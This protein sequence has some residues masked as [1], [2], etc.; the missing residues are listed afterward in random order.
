M[1]E[2]NM[3]ACIHLQWCFPWSTCP[4][5]HLWFI[6]LPFAWI[7]RPLYLL[8]DPSSYVRGANIHP[9]SFLVSYELFSPCCLTCPE[10]TPQIKLHIYIDNI[11]TSAAPSDTR[12]NTQ[13]LLLKMRFIFIFENNIFNALMG[14]WFRQ[15]YIYIYIKWRRLLLGLYV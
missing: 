11:T 2:I 1:Y 9:L 8:G 15:I 5:F 12:I 3:H 6:P 10:D 4:Y 7:N 14:E 13:S